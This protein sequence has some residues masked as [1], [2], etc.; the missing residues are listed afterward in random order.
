MSAKKLS[1]LDQLLKDWGKLIGR[2]I[3]SEEF[4][5]RG[6][7]F[8]GNILSDNALNREVTQD[9]IQHLVNGK[10]DLNPLFRDSGYSRKTKLNALLPP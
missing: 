10:G 1:P 8:V 9:E 4:R 5:A 3:T 6:P 7:G 2:V